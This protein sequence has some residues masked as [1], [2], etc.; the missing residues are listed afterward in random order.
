MEL[1]RARLQLRVIRNGL[2]F[3]MPLQVGEL[4]IARVRL[5]C[6]DSGS[7]VFMMNRQ[8]LVIASGDFA[9]RLQAFTATW[10]FVSGASIITTSAGVDIGFTSA[11][12][13]SGLPP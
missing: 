6:R 9:Q 13:V 11:C 12:R 7:F 2:T 8:M 3:S 10:L 4:M 5:E 1:I